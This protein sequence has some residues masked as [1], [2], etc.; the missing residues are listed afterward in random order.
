[1]K[2]PTIQTVAWGLAIVASLGVAGGIAT[3]IARPKPQK[4]TVTET[5][6]Q[7]ETKVDEDLRRKVDEL[8]Q[9]NAH[10]Q[11]QLQAQARH[12][13]DVAT[14]LRETVYRGEASVVAALLAQQRGPAPA[15]VI[16]VVTP[17]PKGGSAPAP[18]TSPAPVVVVKDDEPQP[19]PVVTPPLPVEVIVRTRETVDKSRTDSST[20]SSATAASD[21][22]VKRTEDEDTQR[23]ASAK[24]DTVAKTVAEEKPAGGERPGPKLGVGITSAQ[25]PFASY[26]LTQLRSARRW[27]RSAPASS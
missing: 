27:G 14:N 17:E 2:P 13:A 15:P 8:T 7:T 3:L 12:Q 9:S 21:T 24:T 20:T 19:A 5:R 4:R 10:L 23:N 26:D 25:Q 18:A 6:V 1:M 11:V 16:N 22:A